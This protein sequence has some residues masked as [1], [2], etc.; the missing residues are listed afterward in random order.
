MLSEPPNGAR[1]SVLATLLNP[2]RAR[3]SCTDGGSG[4]ASCTGTQPNGGLIPTGLFALGRHTF[5]VTAT[6]S[7]GNTTTVTH[8]YQV[9]L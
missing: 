6:D 5:T 4:V 9:T 8:G 2:V 1:Y 3:Y 7:V